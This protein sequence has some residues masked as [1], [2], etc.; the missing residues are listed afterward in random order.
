MYLPSTELQQYL[1]QWTCPYCIMDLKD[2]QKKSEEVATQTVTGAPPEKDFLFG[3]KESE[4]CDRCKRKLVIV[5][6]FNNRKLCEICI[7]REKKDFEESGSGAMPMILKFKLKGNE[8]LLF[9][10]MR[11][12]KV[13]ISRIME[14]RKSSAVQAK[15]D[16]KTDRKKNSKEEDKNKKSDDKE[17]RFEKYFED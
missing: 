9:R 16:N 10:L 2:A 5:Y 12:L 7:D 14:K 15:K 6:I 8:G 17:D 13:A 4:F 3:N 1:G 11:K